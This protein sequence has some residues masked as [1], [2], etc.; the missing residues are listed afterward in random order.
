MIEA[1]SHLRLVHFCITQLIG[2]DSVFEV[3]VFPP[4]WQNFLVRA[5]FLEIYNEEV[6]PQPCN[7]NPESRTPKPE[8]RNPKSET[9]NPKPETPNPKPETR[10]PKP[11][12]RNP[13]P[14][15]KNQKPS[16]S[17]LNPIQ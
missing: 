2:S 3:T 4:G 7:L 16:S 9:R 5:S 17:T 11:E 8:T 13:K 10:S 15:T 6:N 14:Q 1:G 12:T